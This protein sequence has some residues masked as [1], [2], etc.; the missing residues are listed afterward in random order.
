MLARAGSILEFEPLRLGSGA[1]FSFMARC[2]LL[3]S[4]VFGF[5]FSPPACADTAVSGVISAD[6]HWTLAGSPFVINGDVV[7]QSG[8][9]VTI[10]AGVIVY[11][12]AN[13]N[14]SVISGGVKATG[15]QASPVRVLSDKIRIGSLGAPGDWGHWLFASGT[16]NT[17]L[18]YV[19]F[20]NGQG[21]TVNG[22]APIFNYLNLRN[23]QG[24]AIAVDLS[25]SPTGI[26]NQAS[27]N[28]LNGI[29]VPAGDIASNVT[30][31]L[32]GIP[33]VVQ[34]GV[35]SVGASPAVTSMAP[36]TIERGQTITLSIDGS[37]LGGF[38]SAV[39][40]HS[41]LT[42]IPFSGGTSSHLNLQVT[43]APTATL[44]A[45]ALR[46]QVDA[47][48]MFLP[49][50]L[51]V[52]QPLPALSTI[53][54]TSILAGSGAQAIV[55]TGHNFNTQSEVLFNSASVTTTYVSDTE[56]HASLP[57]QSGTG[58]LTVQVRNPD[59]SN[60][61]QYLLSGTTSLSVTAPVPPT[62]GFDLALI[63]MP[64]DGNAHNLT[65]RLS[66][67]D[68]VDHTISLSMSD[69]SKATVSPASLTIS[70]GQTSAVFSIR[71]L[72]TG[73][74]TLTVSASGLSSASVPIFV[75]SDFLGVNTSYAAPV[76]VVVEI[77]PAAPQTA[78]VTLTHATVGV[79]VGAALTGISP[80]GW[81]VGTTQTFTVSG[82]GIPAGVQVSIVPA[83]GLTIGAATVAADGKSMSF[84]A[85]AAVDA[86]PGPRQV[87]VR[88]V[89]G[90]PLSFANAAQAIVTLGTAR[91]DSVSPLFATQGSSVQL[92]VSGSNLQGA[93]VQFLP[94][95]GI[96]VDSRPI[97]NAS[98]T[99]LTA[100]LR[101][102]S[103]T[104]LG[105][106]VVQVVTPAG[107]TGAD[108]SVYN[109]FQ[110]VSAIKDTYSA[111]TAPM[112]GILVGEAAPPPV[113]VAAP[114]LSTQIGVA[115]G[116]SVS[117]VLPGAGVIGTDLVVT[118][119]GQGLQ[120]VTSV[121]IKPATDLTIGAPTANADG[122]E[123]TFSLHVNATAVLGL[124]QLN[125]NTPTGLLIFARATDGAFLITAPVPE[126]QYAS[127]RP[128]ML[129]SNSMTIALGGRNFINVS[130][131]RLS[132]ADGVTVAGP[133]VASADGSNL[134]FTLSVA[135]GATTGERTVIVT[136]VAGDSSTVAVPGNTL[137]LASSVG[138]TYSAISSSMVGVVVGTDV[139]TPVN[140]D[141]ALTSQ[142]VGVMVGDVVAESVQTNAVAPPVGVLVGSSALTMSPVG[143]LQGASGSIIVTGTA[144]D[145]IVSVSVLPNTGVLPGSPVANGAGS[146]LTIP[147]ALAP[148]APLINRRLRL[149]TSSGEVVWPSPASA[150]FG[151][152][153]LPTMTSISPI[154]LERAKN[155]TLA[156][157]GTKLQGVTGVSFEPAGGVM[158]GGAPVWTTDG[159]GELL[160]VSL[161][162]D[163]DA[164]L[165]DRVL[166]LNVPGGATSSAPTEANTVKFV[167][168][169]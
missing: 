107:S 11:M 161:R 102:D 58:S 82:N 47:G 24:P 64:P 76:G 29:A 66:K 20:E 112:V 121:S 165:G 21:L 137:L 105:P 92:I 75:T 132:P 8:A 79:N 6:T 10:D 39:F 155:Y 84:A 125:L 103:S 93:R 43:A 117:Q 48:E 89:A 133:Y 23:H 67:A 143:W 96:E 3:A 99:Q 56:L 159:L 146:Q 135:A 31:G 85:T 19:I 37:R 81:A 33:Y 87:I 164:V 145:Q 104:V 59:P 74:T 68:S 17:R 150:I 30:W 22:S 153:A 88:D 55:I 63:A 166:R 77:P 73:S 70:A 4:L 113:Q 78:P 158:T 160:S 15:T 13:A 44:G 36:S 122:T 54:P 7:I 57:N 1:M 41:G 65:L 95:S 141:G 60:P 28:T 131:V 115:V 123:V 86:S 156:I 168:Q 110:V 40:D 94:G 154:V 46:L 128:V 42:V 136:S 32:R 129:G 90:M 72:S 16:V 25:A 101:I 124:R 35:V 148:D 34:S 127:P 126:V 139:A 26:G 53:A 134:T 50:T 157:R 98:G 114:V 14:V 169:P 51:T 130:G 109:T 106:K 69:T 147:L 9:V 38:G 71:P 152:G 163:A 2:C 111:I 27:G 120:A 149:F 62:M 49:N 80:P 140:Y 108:S 18:D 167:V 138:P 151:I 12:G 5:C 83:T 162:I 45:T 52:T 91:I 97:I 61:G 142:V 118:V 144:L 119:K 116:A 100:M